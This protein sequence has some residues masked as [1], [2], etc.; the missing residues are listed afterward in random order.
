MNRERIFKVFTHIYW[1]LFGV[2]EHILVVIE[3]LALPRT[4]NRNFGTDQ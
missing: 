3:Y 2:F 4:E 1:F